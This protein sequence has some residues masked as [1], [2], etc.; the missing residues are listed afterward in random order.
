CDSRLMVSI[1]T[2]AS[3]PTSMNPGCRSMLTV[4]KTG[5]SVSPCLF[6]HAVASA[7]A[8][9]RAIPV[10]NLVFILVLPLRPKDSG[11][12]ENQQLVVLLGSCL[13][14]EQVSQHRDLPEA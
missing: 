10:K 12:D 1:C 8:D 2:G 3:T 14:A 6:V 5:D 13:V 4:M 7:N 9:A 11:S